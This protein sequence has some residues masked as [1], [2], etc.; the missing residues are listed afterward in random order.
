MAKAASGQAGRPAD[1]QTD[2]QLNYWPETITH[3]S[4]CEEGERK[5]SPERKDRLFREDE[6]S[7]VFAVAYCSNKILEE[8]GSACEGN[9]LG[10]EVDSV[11][12]GGYGT[13]FARATPS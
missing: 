11:I 10:T 1:K 6:R 13:V 3:S 5:K 12:R 4:I 2:R 8:R 7:L 9:V